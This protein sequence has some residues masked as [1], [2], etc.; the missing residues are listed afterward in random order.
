M[1]NIFPMQ[2]GHRRAARPGRTI[3]LGFLFVILFGACLLHLPIAAR[4][5]SVTAFVD[6]LFTATSAT[7]VTGLVGRYVAALDGIRTDCCF[8]FDSNRRL[9]RYVGDG[10]G[11]LLYGTDDYYAGTIGNVCVAQSG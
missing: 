7:C 11:V 10:I 4:D 8:R 6:C 5:H 2:R 3:L 9:G 1:Q